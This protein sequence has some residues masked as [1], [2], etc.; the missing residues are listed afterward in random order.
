MPYKVDGVYLIEPTTQYIALI[1][2]VLLQ[3]QKKLPYYDLK[4]V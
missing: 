1:I 4:E 3:T 2:L